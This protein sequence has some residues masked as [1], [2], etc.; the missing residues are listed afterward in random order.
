MAGTR[1]FDEG[2]ALERALEVFW[3]KGYGATSMQDLAEATGVQRG[4]LY[5]AYRD[6]ESLFLH[7]FDKYK[8]NILTEVRAALD[9]PRLEDALRAFFSFSIASMTSGI[10]ARGCLSTK[11]A[12]DMAA[13][14]EKIHEQLKGLVDELERALAARLSTEE[15]LPQLNLPPADAARLLATL[16]RG[17]VVMERIYQDPERLRATAEAMIRVLLR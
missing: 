9:R 1:Q 7:V 12:V 6:K 5:N 2:A 14:G 15:A 8:N 4:S 10:P 3:L 13:A 16:T 11:T 17:I